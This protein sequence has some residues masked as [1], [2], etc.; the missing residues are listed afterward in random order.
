MIGRRHQSCDYFHFSCDNRTVNKYEMCHGYTLCQD[1]TDLEQCS[2]LTCDT[3][4][5]SA[6]PRQSSCGTL[7]NTAHRECYKP[8]RGNDGSYDCL[9]RRDEKSVTRDTSVRIDF[10]ELKSFKDLYGKVCLTCGS[11]CVPRYDWCREEKSRPCETENSSF[12]TASKEICSNATIWR[13]K[14]IRA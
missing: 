12:N 14:N 10:S 3:S 5:Y 7:E 4:R 6:S 11:D 13:E 1:G 2:A 9:N 8:S